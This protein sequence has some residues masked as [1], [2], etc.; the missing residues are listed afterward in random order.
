M[1]V[2]GPR[3]PSGCHTIPDHRCSSTRTAIS[4]FPSSSAELPALLDAMAAARVTH[5]LCI[6]VN[7]A[8]LARACMRSRWRTR[9][10][11]RPSAC[12]RITRTRREPSVDD[13]AGAA[14]RPKVVAIGETGLD[15]YRLDRRSRVAARALSHAHTRGAARRQAARHP[16]AR[17]RRRHARDHARGGCPRCR[18]RDALLHG[19]LGCRTARRSTWDSTSRCRAS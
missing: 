16:H 18:R 10:S 5:A 13:L 12:I 3:S 11:T 4:T 1:T 19:N 14:A 9:I 7:L 8:R 2:R 15:Y 6:S 17:R